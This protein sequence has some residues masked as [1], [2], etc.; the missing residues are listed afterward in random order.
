MLQ[1]KDERR[2]HLQSRRIVVMVKLGKEKQGIPGRTP[3]VPQAVTKEVDF[4]KAASSEEDHRQDRLS[5]TWKRKNSTLRDE[6][7]GS[8]ARAEE[9]RKRTRQAP[10]LTDGRPADGNSK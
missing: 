7:E 4:P 6:R 3:I 5:D 8:E 2:F 10:R 9:R 1:R